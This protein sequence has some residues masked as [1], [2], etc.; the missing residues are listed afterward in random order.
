MS[1]LQKAAEILHECPY[2]LQ[3]IDE[4]YYWYDTCFS[5]ENCIFPFYSGNNLEKE[6]EARRQADAIENWL[7]RNRQGLLIRCKDA[8]QSAPLSE[9]DGYE[10]RK[11]RI[12]WCLEELIK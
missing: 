7:H 2:P 4:E 12:K 6:C 8:V 10:K 3:I 5:L 11:N 1:I 9:Y